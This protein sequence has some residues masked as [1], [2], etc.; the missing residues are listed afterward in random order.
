MSEEWLES[1]RKYIAQTI[2]YEFASREIGSDGYRCSA[3][4]E[5]N[6][7]DAAW[8]ELVEATKVEREIKSLSFTRDELKE[9]AKQFP[10]PQQWFD[11]TY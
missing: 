4:E 10:A 9:L 2:E 8:N 6:E 1:L 5:R 3:V 7:R 11:E